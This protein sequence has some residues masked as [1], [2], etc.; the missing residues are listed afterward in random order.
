MDDDEDS[1]GTLSKKARRFSWIM[2]SK[3]EPEPPAS[4]PERDESP[5]ST[6]A[7]ETEDVKAVTEGVKE[8]DLEDKE[9][10]EA[11]TGAP[12]VNG[13]TEQKL[14]EDSPERTD[15]AS[16]TPEPE[17]SS[18]DSIETKVTEPSSADAAKS[19]LDTDKDTPTV[20]HVAAPESTDATEPSLPST[21]TVKS[22]GDRPQ[23]EEEAPQEEAALAEEDSES[24]PETPEADKAQ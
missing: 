8:V 19:S 20:P 16:S 5:T 2:N 14:E 7:K 23:A 21:S 9:P 11:P 1:P 6:P 17:A 24:V 15:S 18:P 10:E 22:A 12:Q 13:H 3:A 4:S